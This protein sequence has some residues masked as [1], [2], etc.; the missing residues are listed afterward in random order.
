MS[1]MAHLLKTVV[2]WMM[3]LNMQDWFL[4]LVGTVVIGAYFLRGHGSRSEY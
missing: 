4:V 1:T 2:R 3:T